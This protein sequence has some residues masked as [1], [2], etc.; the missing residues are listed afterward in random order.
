[1][2]GGKCT[3]PNTCACTHGY[4]GATCSQSLHQHHHG[5]AIE[6]NQ[7]QDHAMCMSWGGQHYVTFD[8]KTF[9]YP[10]T[11][12]YTMVQD[13]NEVPTYKVS[14][15]QNYV[16]SEEGCLT[17]V[18]IQIKGLTVLLAPEGVFVNSVKVQL[19]HAVD[20]LVLT[21]HASY[22]I[23]TGVSELKLMYDG[24]SS[25]HVFAPH[26]LKKTLCGM[27]GNYNDGQTDEFQTVGGKQLEDQYSA[28]TYYL[29]P[30]SAAH[31]PAINKPASAACSAVSKAQMDK[32]EQL[33]GV[34]THAP[35]SS[36]NLAVSPDNL[37]ALCETDMCSC[38]SHD[39]SLDKCTA[40][41][42][43][44]AATQY[45][46]SCVLN[47]V[48]LSWRT[49]TFC[50]APLCPAGMVHLECGKACG[51][52]CGHDSYDADCENV[53]CVDGCFC[54]TGT[55][56]DGTKCVP[57]D[58]CSCQR[59]LINYPVGASYTD[60][61]EKCTCTAGARWTCA[62]TECTGRCVLAGDAY[63]HTF[64][65]RKFA[66]VGQCEYVL[67]Q[68]SQVAKT[69]S[70]FSLWVENK[71]CATKGVCPKAVTLQVGTGVSA[72]VFRL[73][74]QEVY[75]N[76]VSVKLP[77]KQDDVTIR[78]LDNILH[79]VTTVGVKLQWNP[80]STLEVQ[81]SSKLRGQVAGL[82]GNF[83][84]NEE[85]DSLT[86]E[87]DNVKD[88]AQFVESWKTTAQCLSH[89]DPKS[90]MLFNSCS[91]NSKYADYAK[92]V[93]SVLTTGALKGCN[94]VV[95]PGCFVKLCEEQVC[96]CGSDAACQCAA[97]AAYA[98]ECALVGHVV[99][100]W[101]V[102]TKCEMK[103]P[104]GQVYQ[105]CGRSCAVNCG[106][107]QPDSCAEECIPGCRCP[108][109]Q[110]LDQELNECVPVKNCKCA[111]K[112]V[113]YDNAAAREDQ[114]NTCVC[115]S[116][117]WEC[118]KHDCFAHAL[119]PADKL[120]NQCADCQPTC[121][122]MHLAC[123]QSRCRTAGCTCAPGTVLNSATGKCVAPT[124]CPCS[125][126]GQTVSEGTV[127]S[128]DC[129][130]CKCTSG[131]MLCTNNQCSASCSASGDR[132]YTTFD[133][134]T[135]E[136]QGSCAYILAEDSC[137]GKEGTFRVTAENVPCGAAG[138]ACTKSIVFTV[139]D[140]VFHLVRGTTPIVS[141]RQGASGLRAQ[142]EIVD[143]GMYTFIKTQHGISIQWDRAMRVQIHVD[144]RH[145]GQLCGLCGNFDG[146]TSNDYR[147]RTG[148]IESKPL[149]FA[150]SWRSCL[151]CPSAPAPL[152]PCVSHPERMSAAKTACDVLKGP[153]FAEC[154]NAVEVHRYYESCV[155]DT[156]AC[157]GSANCDQLCTNVAAYAQACNAKGVHV[158]WRT[159]TLCPMSCANDHVYKACGSSC[160][161][162]C[163]S[164]G[165]DQK[166]GQ[167]STPCVEGCH[168]P[169]DTYMVDGRCVPQNDCP[170]TDPMSGRTYQPEETA[171]VKMC[172]A[173]TCHAGAWTNCVQMANC[174]QTA[175]EPAI[176]APATT[177]E[178]CTKMG[179]IACSVPAGSCGKMCDGV[180]QC[181][182][183]RDEE[184]CTS[185]PVVKKPTI[186]K[187]VL[188]KPLV[189]SDPEVK[190]PCS[191]ACPARCHS[192]A[193]SAPCAEPAS[194]PAK[195]DAPVCECK[196]GYARNGTL[197]IPASMCSCY[198]S[199][200][201]LVRAPYA[202]WAD[203]CQMCQCVDNEIKCES[204]CATV[205]C[206]QEGYGLVYIA[207][208]CCPTCGKLH[209]VCTKKALPVDKNSLQITAADT[210]EL[211]ELYESRGVYT[212]LPADKTAQLKPINVAL[213]SSET[214]MD[215]SLTVAGPVQTVS[216]TFGE[217]P[218]AVKKTLTV[219]HSGQQLTF[220][221][222]S[223][224]LTRYMTVTLQ[225]AA[226]ELQ[227]MYVTQLHIN[228]CDKQAAPKP[229]LPADQVALL[230]LSAQK[231]LQLVPPK[232]LPP[233]PQAS[234]PQQ[235]PCPS[236][237]LNHDSID[238]HKVTMTASLEPSKA[239]E[240]LLGGT[241][242]SV[243]PT[244]LAP[245]KL[246]QTIPTTE[247]RVMQISMNVQG[248]KT[249]KVT[250]NPLSP[251]QPPKTITAVL[252][253][254]TANT[255]L[256]LPVS[257]PMDLSSVTY[258]LEPTSADTPILFHNLQ[259][260]TSQFEQPTDK[261]TPV[262]T[263]NKLVTITVDSPDSKPLSPSTPEAAIN[264]P[265][266][267]QTPPTTG[268]SPQSNLPK[269]GASSPSSPHTPSTPQYPEKCSVA[270][271]YGGMTTPDTV[272]VT[273]SISASEA[274]F[275][276]KDSGRTFEVRRGSMSAVTYTLVMPS[277]VTPR[278][279][280]V[281]F[282]V[283]GVKKVLVNF[284]KDG[285]AVPQSSQLKEFP[286]SSNKNSVLLELAQ[287][288]DADYVELFLYPASLVDPIR[289][290]QLFVVACF[291]PL[292][293][294]S[295]L[296]ATPAGGQPGMSAGQK[297]GSGP[298]SPDS[299][300]LLPVSALNP[301]QLGLVPQ[302]KPS[303]VGP[304]PGSGG[305]PGQTISTPATQPTCR[306]RMFN[307]QLNTELIRGGPCLGLRRSPRQSLRR[308]AR[309]RGG[310]RP[311]A[312]RVRSA[313][314][315]SACHVRRQ[316]RWEGRWRVFRANVG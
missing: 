190:Q 278:V 315:A 55:L 287:L 102:N 39:N 307:A 243:K 5:H 274:P 28:A 63:Y 170:C 200:T 249:A 176:P 90:P 93:C 244:S 150:N 154:H 205:I 146:Q 60:K 273:A 34:L 283:S 142:Y 98:R 298:L 178:M 164:L 209:E 89:V 72:K 45:S 35:F 127:V 218:S 300:A 250:L 103:C 308:E 288:V 233:P 191:V 217:G 316:A 213:K 169:D 76:D 227:K 136:F 284:Y 100:S 230:S 204:S 196:D 126:H 161:L 66:F 238:N 106:Q 52:T 235:G 73:L 47:G 29:D 310:H 311:A 157:E 8:K 152:S 224:V 242:Y 32:I 22:V 82:C 166:S 59:D 289:L 299:T 129:N 258:D 167:C 172:R 17:A 262:A 294:G 58:Q 162:T 122:N 257:P 286:A 234:Q 229:A 183:P 236:T 131:R 69:T 168:C 195:C 61:C 108:E 276:L 237:I 221:T 62:A 314:S 91:V 269:T 255:P 16:C 246:H 144:P 171:V 125:F 92:E 1:M 48:T 24:H 83:N 101:A 20:C 223:G 211:K 256:V 51:R 21:Q 292:R 253:D 155:Y 36:C 275:A 216:A 137:Y 313:S 206:T 120:W 241:G 156:C 11:G 71:L 140:T 290:D 280:H 110:A 189:C 44:E 95:D 265:A 70:S 247:P 145:R 147:A 163:K 186:T 266:P 303:S 74:P 41:I 14:V 193:A 77:Y 40:Q 87:G 118:T 37:V 133:G 212:Y 88:V 181:V 7:F 295:H 23:V 114:C 301:K 182:L 113:Y 4:I 296:P 192:M 179:M 128:Q 94:S 248:V 277:A 96:S 281:S 25:L 232:R 109:G 65:G 3:A 139:H 112:G 159:P 225:H 42:Q 174:G 50:P 123:P 305:Q 117:V 31:T 177:A 148:Q 57:A 149:T 197:C 302:P 6:K 270:L 240:A 254:P 207:G 138:V 201:K 271:P 198:D 202:R 56:L 285:I 222:Q 297:P 268:G 79:V 26:T 252:K 116:G 141:T 215:L 226:G 153:V 124:A 134:Q 208:Q 75:V 80:T 279:S 293:S 97:L 282:D 43:C 49:A 272:K 175:S 188:P 111:H 54:P 53:Q 180:A 184:N 105:E 309:A 135:F 267:G 210:T 78:I 187:T 30:S 115:K 68:P 263:D 84:G 104:A 306:P 251:T 260:Q 143:A 312:G 15:N 9:S 165:A 85:D 64:D 219:H 304:Q 132:H 239:P 214:V 130:T 19:P 231:P 199:K 121:A 158:R 151:S 245:V 2:N 259:V 13:C 203:G 18:K 185:T 27:C 194:S 86:V 264:F 119:C 38:L 107:V 10:G 228:V 33:C 81:L 173:C 67:V 99:N 291:E 12:T 220:S 160:P 46:R 261:V